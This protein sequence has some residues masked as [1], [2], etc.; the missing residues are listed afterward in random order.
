MKKFSQRIFKGLSTDISAEDISE[1]STPLCQDVVTTPRGA[2]STPLGYSKWNTSSLGFINGGYDYRSRVGQYIFAGCST[3]GAGYPSGGGIGTTYGGVTIDGSM[4]VE[5]GTQASPPVPRAFTTLVV[6]IP[7]TTNNGENF[8]ITVTAKDQYNQTFS[9]DGTVTLT[10]NGSGTLSSSSLSMSAGVATSSTL[11]YLYSADEA[12]VRITASIS[13]KSGYDTMATT[14]YTVDAI[15][16]YLDDTLYDTAGAMSDT[17]LDSSLQ[18]TATVKTEGGSTVTTY[19]TPLTV[20]VDSGSLTGG[21]TITMSS[22]TGS[23]STKWAGAWTTDNVVV[24][25]GSASLFH[26]V[27]TDSKSVSH[28]YSTF[29]PSGSGTGPLSCTVQQYVKG[30]G[31]S[32]YG[33]GTFT[34]NLIVGIPFNESPVQGT[35]TNGSG[36]GGP[37]TR[38]TAMTS[39][40]GSGLRNSSGTTPQSIQWNA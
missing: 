24:T 22:G 8:T 39:V 1:L 15:Y 11:Q 28:L 14:G 25:T 21:S 2:L 35:I 19:S 12:T 34:L 23:I 27:S 9:L 6:E 36:S 18:I 3:S 32:S 38:V 40:Y 17:N 13:G 33:N 37:W 7:A 10:D 29:T 20:Y 16:T 26:A 31:T 4:T 5:S 30:G